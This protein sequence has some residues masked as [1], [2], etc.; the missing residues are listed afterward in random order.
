M[1]LGDIEN[2]ENVRRHRQDIC[3]AMGVEFTDDMITDDYFLGTFYGPDKDRLDSLGLINRGFCPICGREPIGTEYHRRM[4]FSKAVEYLCKQC[5]DRTNP[6]ATIPGYTRR[7]RTAKFM[8]SP[9][10]YLV[11]IGFL[12]VVFFL[13]WALI[14]LFG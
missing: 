14:R 9:L 2:L 1:E 13:V 12:V 7:Y 6:H 4:V 10:R 11:S 3:K 5:Y 8:Q